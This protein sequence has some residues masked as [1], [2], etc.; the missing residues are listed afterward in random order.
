[1][2]I[3][4]LGVGPT[5]AVF[6]LVVQNSVRIQ[7]LGSA[8]S[9]LTF[10]QQVG[11][12]V[13]LAVTGTI[14]ATTMAEQTPRLLA[15]ANVP[16]EALGA[17]G[18]ALGRPDLVTS[19]GPLGPKILGA[20]PDDARAVVEPFIDSIVDAIYRAFSLATASTFTVGIVAAV[21]A[22]GLVLLYR[23]Q[24]MGTTEW[25]ESPH[26]AAPDAPAGVSLPEG[27]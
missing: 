17:A 26:A 23:E 4:G 22:A 15:A 7:Q 5:F 3:T 2:L 6:T 21:I 12:T 24:R 16:P 10:F 19:V 8:T 11:G 1:M 14:F 18:S 9:N 27:G 20:L 13:G 25:S